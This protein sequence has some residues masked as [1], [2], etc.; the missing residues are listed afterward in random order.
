M[1]IT[2]EK[3]DEILKKLDDKFG[4]AKSVYFADYRGLS[5]QN[6]GD[7]RQKLREEGVEYVIAK[8]TLMKLSVKNANL[9]E[10]PDELME[11]PVGAAFGYED[12]IA[13]VK[14]LHNYAKEVDALQI[15]GGLV[16]GKYITKAEAT[17]LA[18][19]PSKDELLAKLVGSLKSPISGFHGVL[20]GVLRNFVGVMGAYQEKKGEEAPA[21]AAPEEAAPA[22]KPAEDAA[23]AEKTEEAAKAE[24]KEE[25]SAKK[26]DPA[27]AKKGAEPAAEAEKPEEKE[28]KPEATEE[29][30]AK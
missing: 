29:P 13:P 19:L 27:E 24:P 5:V 21:E 9:P 12:E 30:E 26:E 1:A 18:K 7:L 15:L 10:I 2:K 22:E 3:K 23:P 6:M 8:K 20:S 28:D 16:E 17:E 25:E 14:I 11:G 4:K